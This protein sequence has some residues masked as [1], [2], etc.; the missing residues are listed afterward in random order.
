LINDFALIYKLTFPTSS[1]NS[2]IYGNFGQANYSAAKLGV[3]GLANTIAI[4][5]AKYNIHCNTIC[6]TAGSRMTKGILPDEFFDEMKPVLI[7]PVVVYLCHEDT[8]DNAQIIESAIGY[9]T[10]VHFVRGKGSLIRDSITDVPTPES[11]KAKWGQITDMER[12]KH[13]NSN[14]EVSGTFME[15]IEKLKNPARKSEFEDTYSYT[16]RELIMYALGI[17]VSTTDP[18]NLRFLYENHPD[19]A[20]FPTFAVIPGI[21]LLMTSQVTPSAL[22]SFDLS[23]VCLINLPFFIAIR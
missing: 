9:A 20:P 22:E 15:V 17:G 5:G 19:F 13:Y 12:A 11:V 10:K 18:D 8:K 21:I 23:Q 14:V 1:S 3:V 16:F 7:A 6:P 2:G 4:E